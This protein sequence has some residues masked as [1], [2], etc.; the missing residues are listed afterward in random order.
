MLYCDKHY[1]YLN[2]TINIYYQVS[3]K[4]NL[5]KSVHICDFNNSI[6]KIYSCLLKYYPKNQ[7]SKEHFINYPYSHI[8]QLKDA[9]QRPLRW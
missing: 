1:Y 9:W 8:G 3:P 4:K 5:Q 2:E 7:N 6:I